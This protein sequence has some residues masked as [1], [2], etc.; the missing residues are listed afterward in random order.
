VT[1]G[2]TVAVRSV[3]EMGVAGVRTAVASE[4]D[5]AREVVDAGD[6]LP[7]ELGQIATE[8]TVRGGLAVDRS[9]QVQITQDRRRRRSKTS[10]TASTI[11]DS[12]TVF[13]PNVST[14]MLIGCAMPI[15]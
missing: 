15:A 1:S 7:G 11:F 5:G 10:F 8:V 12:S 3:A 4:A 14:R 6:V 13:V 9:L 2:R